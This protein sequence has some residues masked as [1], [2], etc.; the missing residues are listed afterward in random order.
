M[1]FYSAANVAAATSPCKPGGR[2][3]RTGE[4]ESDGSGPARGRGVCEH[5]ASA[6]PI[7][8]AASGATLRISGSSL[9]AC[10]RVQEECADMEP[11]RESTLHQER[12]Q[13]AYVCS[14]L[15]RPH[16]LND[17]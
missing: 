15:Q 6:T 12:N 7:A 3:R 17:A 8:A 14:T 16:Q 11:P 5:A 1:S 2:A 4:R 10:A 9:S 13:V